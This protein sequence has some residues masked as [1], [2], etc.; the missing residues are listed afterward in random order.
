V[1][2]TQCENRPLHDVAGKLFCQICC[3]WLSLITNTDLAGS[4]D[5]FGAKVEEIVSAVA[6]DDISATR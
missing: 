6:I 1:R 2:D 4:V 5:I 3:I